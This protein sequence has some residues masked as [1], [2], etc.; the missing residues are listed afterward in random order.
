MFWRPC[1]YLINN[2]LVVAKFLDGEQLYSVINFLGNVIIYFG[3]DELYSNF[4]YEKKIN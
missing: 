4:F 3:L 2:I 1:S